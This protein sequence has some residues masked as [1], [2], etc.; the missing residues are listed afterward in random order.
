M[1]RIHYL[2]LVIA[3][4]AAHQSALALCQESPAPGEPLVLS[5]I[6]D[7]E[8]EQTKNAE[9]T[10]TLPEE[11]VQKDEPQPDPVLEPTPSDVETTD[12]ELPQLE[13]D[14]EF[15]DEEEMKEL[16]KQPLFRDFSNAI[17]QVAPLPESVNLP[18]HDDNI[19][20]LNGVAPQTT[21]TPGIDPA[22]ESILDESLKIA[23]CDLEAL[24]IMPSQR[25]ILEQIDAE[26][27]R[28]WPLWIDAEMNRNVVGRRE[29]DWRQPDP[30]RFDV[31]R[32]N[33][34]DAPGSDWSLAIDPPFFFKV[35]DLADG[36]EYYTQAGN[37]EKTAPEIPVMLLREGRQFELAK[38]PPH[39]VPTGNTVRYRVRKDGV[40]QGTDASGR[41]VTDVHLGAIHVFTFLNPERLDSVDG[42]FFTPTPFSGEPQRVKL[43][44]ATKTGVTQ[45]KLALSNG[46]PEEILARIVTLCK[47]KRR[48]VELLSQPSVPLPKD[49]VPAPAPSE[50]TPP[51]Q[52][53]FLDP[54][55]NFNL[56]QD[57]EEELDLFLE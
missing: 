22:L 7:E 3:A 15:I 2:A 23:D 53:P 16:S 24:P 41:I 40:V 29:R 54:Q 47:T 33:L 8:P 19:L 55:E 34:I 48:L 51:S 9:E 6:T 46:K 44:P 21:A 27:V 36:Q 5:A 43:L 45:Y 52:P 10:E 49:E 31:A 38:D 18:N 14:G 13:L 11:V 20:N 17:E 28:L 39:V 37:F 4:L 57:S 25:A 12:A 32:P 42:V 50:K 56:N 1:S 26:I 30:T 35:T